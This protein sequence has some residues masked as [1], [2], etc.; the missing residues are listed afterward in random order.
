MVTPLLCGS[1]LLATILLV[2]SQNTTV[3]SF[4]PTYGPSSDTVVNT[5]IFNTLTGIVLILVIYF[6]SGH[7]LYQNDVTARLKKLDDS[8]IVSESKDESAGAK[9]FDESSPLLTDDDQIRL[10]LTS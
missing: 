2:S 8:A 10:S 1:T 4:S 5:I 9:S 3:P 7:Y 6:Y